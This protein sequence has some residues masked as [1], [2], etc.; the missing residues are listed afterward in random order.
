MTKSVIKKVL[1]PINSKFCKHIFEKHSAN[2]Y[3]KKLTAKDL[4]TLFLTAHLHEFK[5]LRD[6]S[7][8]LLFNPD[9]QNHLDLDQIS[10]SQLHRRLSALDPVVLQELFQY[11]VCMLHTKNRT[12]TVKLGDHLNIIDASV[13]S[14]ALTGMEWARYRKNKAGIKLNLA[15]QYHKDETVYPNKAIVSKASEHDVNHML[16]LVDYSENVINLF[17]RGYVDYDKLMQIHTNGGGFLIRIKHNASTWIEKDYPV[18]GRIL[19]DADIY[20]GK[21]PKNP[22]S[23]N[24]YRYIHMITDEGIEMH[25]A[26]NI[27]RDEMDSES[28]CELYRLRW[29]IELFF[30]WIK[31]HMS[32]KHFFATNPTAVQN[33]IFIALILFTLLALFHHECGGKITMNQFRRAVIAALF[34]DQHMF[35][36]RLLYINPH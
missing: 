9:Y 3:M 11:L 6:I 36:Q 19:K 10:H 34:R 25:F 7:T 27:P 22:K 2:R 17:D 24:Q 21:K 29:R 12:Q 18:N 1:E 14:K 15:I 23:E 13:V 5:G 26:T 30:K 31:Q 16:E 32:V 4:V 20:L 33:Q 8:D 28:I 35:I